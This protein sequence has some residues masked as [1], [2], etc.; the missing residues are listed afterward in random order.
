MEEG[1]FAKKEENKNNYSTNVNVLASPK[2][3]KKE[4]KQLLDTKK[5]ER[6]K[7]KIERS[8]SISCLNESG[9]YETKLLAWQKDVE[10][11]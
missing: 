4:K 1:G 6:K 9:L 2:G 10:T 7:R 8:F 11:V 3:D 5:E